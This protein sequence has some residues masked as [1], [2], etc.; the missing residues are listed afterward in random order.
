MLHMKLETRLQTSWET[1]WMDWYSANR[2]SLLRREK[3]HIN[4]NLFMKIPKIKLK[5]VISLSSDAHCN[6]GKEKHEACSPVVGWDLCFGGF[7]QQG[8]FTHW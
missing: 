1:E 8:R 7:L 2:M 5:Q 4:N 3:S 6:R